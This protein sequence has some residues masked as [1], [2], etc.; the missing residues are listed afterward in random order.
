MD[1]P[2]L[3]KIAALSLYLEEHFPGNTPAV[4]ASNDLRRVSVDIEKVLETKIGLSFDTLRNANVLRLP[5]FR[6]K[7]GLIAHPM[8]KWIDPM[9]PGSDWDRADWLEAVVGELGEYANI[10]KKFR[11]GDITEK[12][13]KELGSKE[14]ADVQTYLDILAFQIGVNLAE[15]TRQK[16]NEVSERVKAT[17]F[18]DSDGNIAHMPV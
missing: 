17:V 18:I 3:K 8:D 9:K 5:E 13:F 12:E 2:I 15:A 16:F 10:S 7:H 6:N 1:H 4:A 14:L 11:R